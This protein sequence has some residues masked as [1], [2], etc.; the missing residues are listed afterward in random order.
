MELDEVTYEV[1]EGVAHIVLNRPE[2]LNAISSREGGTRDQLLAAIGRA[3]ADASVGCVVL[4]GAGRSFSGGGDLTGNARRERPIDDRRFLE[5]V[6]QFH[7]RIRSSAL[8][9]V[10]AVHGYCLG[11]AVSLIASCDIVIAGE[12]AR[13]GYPEARLGLVGA[14]AIVPVVGRQWAKFLMLTGELLTSRQ[15]SAIGLVLTVEPDDRVQDR[16]HDLAARIARMPREAVL[17]NRRTI[18][19]VADAGGDAAGRVAAL[20]HDT[21]TASMA[22][23]A[24]A[25][26]GR[27]FQS[28]IEASGIDGMKA[29]QRQQ[30]SEPWL[31]G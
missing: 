22:T 31:I 10:A 29:A 17:L 7:Q 18:D 12:G 2:Q 28:I 20:A 4:S 8:P 15:A 25:P 26:D 19:A 13:L 3:E 27:T 23:H 11:A 14:S 1:R 21:V 9:I 30:F 6:D 24:A 5:A 16:A